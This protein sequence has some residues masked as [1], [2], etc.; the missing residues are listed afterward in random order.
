MTSKRCEHDDELLAFGAMRLLSAAE[1]AQ[2]AARLE[3]CPACRQRAEEYRAL[4]SA[5]PR[6]IANNAAPSSVHTAPKFSAT[7]RSLRL[8]KRQTTSPSED[9][10]EPDQ[11]AS[12]RNHP[13]PLRPGARLRRQQRLWN[14]FSGLAAVLLLAV[15]LAGF[16]WLIAER[17]QSTVMQPAGCFFRAPAGPA[18]TWQCGILVYDG[19][20]APAPQTLVPLD[21]RTGHPLPGLRSLPVGNVILSAITPDHRTLVLAIAPTQ[22]D[23]SAVYL[24]VV[25][26][27]QWKLGPQIKTGHYV[28]ALAIS[29]DGTHIYAVIPEYSN[30][31]AT[32]WLQSYLNQPKGIQAS[33]R[34]TLP[35]L[36][37]SDG[38]AVSRDGATLYAFSEKTT[39]AAQIM[40]AHIEETGLEQV[41]VLQLDQLA[42]GADP[43]TTPYKQGDP[44]PAAY[45]PAII[46]SPDR[47]MLYLVY[48]PYND[49]AHD[50]LLTLYLLKWTGFSDLPITEATQTLANL[51]PGSASPHS[52]LARSIPA[53][54][55]ASTAEP[56][57]GRTEWGVISPDGQWLYVTGKSQTAQIFSDGTWQENTDYLGLWKINA[58]NGKVAGHWFPGDTFNDVH[59]SWDGQTLYLFRQPTDGA[60]IQKPTSL[61]A[62]S[63][64]TGQY[65]LL[66]DLQFQERVILTP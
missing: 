15:L 53:A 50:R 21:P 65:T 26:L 41:Q 8:F 24:Q 58:Q 57:N 61:L 22:S 7:N 28:D 59:M 38:F 46:F 18:S 45:H 23:N 49:P 4:S 47:T 35:F 48:A 1:E 62:F 14:A 6:L 9:E 27:D 16:R 12:P 32:I 19:T 11:A 54:R 20:A 40:Q 44:I 17:G 29:D 31:V 66:F 60:Y 36:P 37:N 25:W 52:S 63:T 42:N 13:Y 64:Q 2:L 30:G 10:K 43:T 51:S 39:P 5:M 3:S 55:L 34:A 56:F 33:W